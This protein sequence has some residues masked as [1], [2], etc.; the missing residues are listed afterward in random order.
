M[1]YC[2]ILCVL[3]CALSPYVSAAEKPEGELISV[4]GAKAAV[5]LVHGRG[6]GPDGNVVSPL[7]HAIAKDAGMHTLSLQMPVLATQ[8]YVAYASTF[9][10][11]YKALAAAIDFFVAEM[12]VERIYL[13]GYSMGARMTS[14]FLATREARPVAG[15]IGI[16]L[17]KG[18]GT[19]LDANINVAAIRVPVLDISADA[20]PLDLAS[21]KD[22]DK[23]TGPR[24]RQ[25]KMAGASHSFSGYEAEMAHVI[26]A[27]LKERETEFAPRTPA[28]TRQ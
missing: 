18:G 11:A 3:L 25:V 27:W 2:K 23:L 26:V 5:I 4:A 16:G 21:A 28:R 6:Q 1:R 20:T 15:Y 8:D 12:D 10:D 7:R 22:R 14:G 17:L 9:P 19:P 13:L 24:Y